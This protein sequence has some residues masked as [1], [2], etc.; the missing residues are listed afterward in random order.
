MGG[1][2]LLW[3]QPVTR[4]SPCA[5]PL[6]ALARTGFLTHSHLVALID[7]PENSKSRIRFEDFVQGTC[8]WVGS[9]TTVTQEEWGRRPCARLAR[10]LC[11]EPCVKL[12]LAVFGSVLSTGSNCR[13]TGNDTRTPASSSDTSS[14]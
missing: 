3:L 13:S 6:R 12:I 8:N 11:A 7:Q 14:R 9:Q 1:C 2:S 4:K 10:G 5:S